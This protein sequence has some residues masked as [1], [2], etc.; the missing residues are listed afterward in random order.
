[1]NSFRLLLLC[2]LFGHVLHEE[3]L[4]DILKDDSKDRE[5]YLLRCKRCGIF[6]FLPKFS[7][8][9]SLERLGLKL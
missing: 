1:M 6:Y 5:N 2:K 3:T 7:N 9:K 8:Y 4:V